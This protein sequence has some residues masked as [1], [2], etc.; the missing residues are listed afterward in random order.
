VRDRRSTGI[1]MRSC[2]TAA[3]AGG[4]EN[5]NFVLRSRKAPIY[6][7]MASF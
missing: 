7:K 4:T 3:K 1:R 2:G 6:S 5:T